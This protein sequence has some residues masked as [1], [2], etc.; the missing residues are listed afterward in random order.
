MLRPIDEIAV[1][2]AWLLFFGTIISLVE[3]HHSMCGIATLRVG[4]EQVKTTVRCTSNR[5]RRAEHWRHSSYLLTKDPFSTVS[6]RPFLP[7]RPGRFP[8]GR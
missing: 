5:S 2:K 4:R 8:A 6:T 7:L 1:A 3:N